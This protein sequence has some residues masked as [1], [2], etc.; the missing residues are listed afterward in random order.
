MVISLIAIFLTEAIS[1]TAV[2]ALLMPITIGIAIDFSISPIITTLAVTVPSGLAFMLPMGTPAVAIAH[3]SGFIT[4]G[5]AFKG[6][7][8]LKIVSWIFFNFFAYYYWPFLGL[9]F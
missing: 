9:G 3:S 5:D 1:N 2:V 8:V 4:P 6:G 7:F